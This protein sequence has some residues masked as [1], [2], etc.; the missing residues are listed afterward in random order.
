MADLNYTVGVSTTRAQQSLKKLQANTKNLGDSLNGLQTI[1]GSIAIGALVR[2]ILLGA[3]AMVNM[4]KATDISVAA[5]TA[6]SQAMAQTGGTADRARDAISDLTKNLGEAARGSA[7]LQESFRQAGVGL[8][9]LRRLSTEDVFR[10]VLE[11][12][13]KIPDAATRSSVAMKILGESVKGVDLKSLNEQFGITESEVGPYADSIKSAAEANKALSVN[14]A[15]FQLALTSV[16]EPLNKIAASINISVEGFKSFIRIIA[17][18][19]AGIFILTKGL[20]GLGGLFNIISKGTRSSAG[21]FFGMGA[22]VKGLSGDLGGATNSLGRFIKGQSKLGTTIKGVTFGIARFGIRFLGIAGILIAVADAANL[23]VKALT[24]FDT[25]EFITDKIGAGW[26]YVKE[27]LG[28]AK[29]EVKEVNKE[30][31]KS[32]DATRN[33][34]TETEKQKDSVRKVKDAAIEL[35]KATNS[36][37]EG[38][39]KS[40]E[41]IITSLKLERDRIGLNSEQIKYLESVSSFQ[42]QHADQL[43]ALRLKAKEQNQETGAGKKN[44]EEIQKQIAILTEKHQEQLP[45]VK[46]I[47]A[48]IRDET[49]ALEKAAEAARL[50]E[51]QTK[52][53]ADAVERASESA[54][55]FS[56]K[57]SDATRDAQNDL[58]MLNMG[59]L[60][61]SIFKIKTGIS[62]DVTNEVRRLQEV[63]AKTGDPDG[64]IAASI[65]NIK[66]AGK[67]AIDAQSTLASQSYNYQRTFAHGWS[68]AFRDYKDDATNASKQAERVFSKATKGMEDSI[69]GFAKTGKFE[70]KGFVSSIL[71]ELLRAQI[72]Q[73]IAQIFGAASPGSL[74]GGGGSSSG[75]GGGGGGMGSMLSGIGNMFGGS[76]SPSKG[77]SGGGLDSIIGSIGS[78][79]GGSSGGSSS[80]GGGFLDSIGSGIS[81]AVSGVGKFFSGFFA[82]GGMIPAGGYG[83]V[84]ER[85]PE[86]VSG[87]AMVTPMSGGQTINYNINAVDAQSFAALVARDPGLIY[88]VTEQGRRSMAT[89]R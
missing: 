47:S 8:E 3:D 74:F 27:K 37:V 70:W 42:K 87:P 68:K 26:D 34:V 59:E 12:L 11:G 52:K 75:G 15:N 62:Q 55:D 66:R 44:Y 39:K 18:L 10:A 56:R 22:A 7:E 69:V 5:I 36:M 40:N 45:V 33:V 28:F 77:S 79:F 86:M 6:F 16:L 71:E 85:G 58:A 38:Y 63:I 49:R 60:E 53:I 51:E 89:R 21:G 14:I 57:M 19:G 9:D 88:A 65:E 82:N 64:Q 67:E 41:E 2:N 61:K 78:L 50:L 23:L 84:G 81:S 25:L 4:S 54:K 46:Q 29:E 73:T 43:D 72:Q 80:S 48:E 32:A 13:T 20:N 76:S 35:L 31:K 24:G 1:I 83:I 17:G 30:I